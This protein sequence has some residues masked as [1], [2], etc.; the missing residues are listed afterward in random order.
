M[1]PTASEKINAPMRMYDTPV[2]YVIVHN[3]IKECMS[4]PDLDIYR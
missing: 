2:L 3:I 1:A 4:H